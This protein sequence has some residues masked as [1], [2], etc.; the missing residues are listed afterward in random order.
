M[1]TV[2]DPS[3]R[4]A[5]FTAIAT[6]VLLIPA[7]LVAFAPSGLLAWLCVGGII[8]LGI[9]QLACAAAF[10]MRTC[11]TTARLLLRASLVYLPAVLTLWILIPVLS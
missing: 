10:R 4:K 3:G 9:G 8:A 6:A 1:L 11:E 5:S 7:S 2:V